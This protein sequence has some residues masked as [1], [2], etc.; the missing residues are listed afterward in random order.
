MKRLLFL[1]MIA[2]TMFSCSS[3]D[4][5]EQVNPVQD[6]INNIWK[7]LKGTYK[8]T[9]YVLNTDNV[10][11]TETIT[12]HPFSEPKEILPIYDKK[13]M[14]YGTVD[15]LDTRFDYISETS[16]SYYSIGLSYL[17]AIPT[18]TFYEYNSD[19]GDIIN[20]GDLRT[21]WISGGDIY[22]GGYGLTKMEDAVKYER[23]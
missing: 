8:G 2:V 13:C 7:S 5:D 21:I 9:Y 14:A 6:E 19:S 4:N 22:L 11:Y 18:I 15:I 17:G 3:S 23:Q 10:W 16:H 12:F 20:K 1:M